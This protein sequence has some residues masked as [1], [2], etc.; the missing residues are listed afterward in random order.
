MVEIGDI[1]SFKPTSFFCDG[2]MPQAYGAPT[3]LKGRVAYI[4]HEHGWFMLEA[5][6]PG[7][8]LRECFKITE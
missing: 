5:E 4:N 1:I 3:T 7:G 2:A 6:F 8:V